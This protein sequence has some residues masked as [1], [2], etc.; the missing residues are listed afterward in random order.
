MDT[1]GERI[2]YYIEKQG[3]SVRSFCV[4]NNV[5]YSGFHQVLQNTRNLGMIVLKQLIEAYP[6]L[7]VNWLLTGKGNVEIDSEAEGAMKEPQPIYGK[8]DP[9]FEAWLK[10]FDNPITTKKLNQI[11]DSKINENG[12]K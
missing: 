12:T 5:G 1:E 3:V 9:G 8:I 4:K 10:Y 6:N 2:R 11:I 7:N